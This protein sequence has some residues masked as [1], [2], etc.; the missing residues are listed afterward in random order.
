MIRLLCS[1]VIVFGVFAADPWA[2]VGE[3]KNGAELRIY[4]KGAK[5]PLLAKMDEVV[6]DK[7]IVVI[8]DEQVAIEKGQIDRLDARPVQ[9]GSRITKETKTST[10]DATRS[11]SPRDAVLGP[12][13][14][15]TSSSSSLSIGSKPDFE[16]IY[17]SPPVASRQ[18][19]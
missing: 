5:Q 8:K 16:I 14:P 4:K 3:I 17:R 1:L 15:G 10:T 2:K 12:T 19:K 9:T 6:D 11:A 18:S 13:T 7:V